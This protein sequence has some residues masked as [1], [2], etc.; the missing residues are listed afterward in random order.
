MISSIQFGSKRIDFHL[1]YSKRKTL[2]ITVT[3][4]MDVLV[5]APTG[6]PLE[7]IREKVKGKA[8]WILAN[9]SR[10][11]VY[12]PKTPKRKFVSGETHLYLGRQIRLKVTLGKRPEVRLG[13][14][15]EVVVSEKSEV[16]KV[17]KQ[18]Y[19]ERA[20]MKFEEISRPLVEKF[21]RFSRVVPKLYLKEM[22]TRWGSCT[23]TGKIILNPELIKAPRGCIE[24]VVLH[25][26]CHLV[27]RNHSKGFFDLQS[28]L[29]PD[30]GKWKARLERLLA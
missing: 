27:H 12:H 10:F 28:R 30:W 18:W 19:R 3:P 1:R 6:V 11:L 24:Y 25:E 8:A 2:G 7:K 16:G 5:M 20:I 4:E 23:S 13:H 17:M 21:R 26:L 9:Q 22:P 14:G 15:I 29:M